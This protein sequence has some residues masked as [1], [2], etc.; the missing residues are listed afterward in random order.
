[1][2]RIKKLDYILR[3]IFILMIIIPFITCQNG[4]QLIHI[5]IFYSLPIVFI[6]GTLKIF[7]DEYPKIRKKKNFNFTVTNGVSTVLL[8]TVIVIHFAKFMI[9]LYDDIIF[10]FFSLIEL[11][12]GV[13][14]SITF[15]VF[16]IE[17][18]SKDGQ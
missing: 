11:I 16:S 9:L 17:K 13:L 3:I 7:A 8:F 18:E 2:N 5:Y 4:L 10:L 6:W 15:V 1:M 14:F 12:L